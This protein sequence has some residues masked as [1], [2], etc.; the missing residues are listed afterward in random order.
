MIA[1]ER[2]IAVIGRNKPH[3]GFTLINTDQK[4]IFEW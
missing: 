2:V 4:W 1:R 3:H